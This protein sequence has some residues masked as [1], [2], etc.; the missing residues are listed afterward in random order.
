MEK[1]KGSITLFSLLA[2]LLVTAALFAL[3]EGT[4]LQEMRRL[5]FLQTQ[6]AL[7][8]A[9]AN[10][11][12]CLWENY[13]LLGA[14]SLSMQEI[15]DKGA[16]GRAGNGMNLLSL[17]AEEVEV[18]ENTRLTDGRGKVYMKCVASYMKE[19][20]VY[21]VGKEAY[22]HFEAIKQ[23][24]DSNQVN[25]SNITDALKAI[26]KLEQEKIPKS[27]GLSMGGKEVLETAKEWMEKGLLNVVLLDT[28]ELSEAR[29]EFNNGLL[30]RTLD[31]GIQSEEYVSTWT[32][33]LLL[34]QYLLN[35]MSSYVTPKEN[36][37]LAYEI[38]YLLGKKDN[39]VENLKITVE[40]LLMVREAA[41]FLYLISNPVRMSQAEGMALVLIGASA[42]PILI[43]AIKIGI[44][45]AWAIGESV[46]DVRALLEG[47]KIALL[48]N[49]ENWTLD[50][51]N[52]SELANTK[53]MATDCV[54]G[55]G[56]EEYLGILL[57]F[58]NEQALAMHA[59]NLQEATIRIQTQDFEF[60][61]DS[62]LT[63]AKAKIRYSYKPVFPFL[64]IINA[65]KRW[66]YEV[67]TE[68]LYGYY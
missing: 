41:N 48:K 49:E 54:L 35:Y 59:M 22:S 58:E 25:A 17:A 30:K 61:M 6:L 32:E 10:Y 13:H 5:A 46:L 11:N 57:L 16:N 67:S 28:E 56:Y 3:L 55:L 33:K 45:T 26:E 9:F 42:N 20:F 63:Q 64:Q 18:K 34:R 40:K 8:S 23:V 37:A 62:L 12:N 43:E 19:N 31:Q 50:F 68:E 53:L 47:K 44:L 36:R 2:L 60:C 52:L 29:E 4:R 24:L 1:K 39:D 14:D 38:E 15:L 21:E 7:E 66:R 27:A 51:S 65:E